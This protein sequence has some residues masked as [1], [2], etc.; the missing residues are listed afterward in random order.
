VLNHGSIVKE[1][2]NANIVLTLEG[3]NFISLVA[4][5]EMHIIGKVACACEVEPAECFIF[6]NFSKGCS[7]EGSHWHDRALLINLV[8][9]VAKAV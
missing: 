9:H 2:S 3:I 6:L 1:V 7:L 8:N 5:A 4:G